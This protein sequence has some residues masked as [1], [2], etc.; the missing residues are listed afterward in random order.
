MKFRNIALSGVLAMMSLTLSAQEETEK[1][2]YVFNPHWYGQLQVG[3]QY[4]R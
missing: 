2:E 1:T 3:G 4:H